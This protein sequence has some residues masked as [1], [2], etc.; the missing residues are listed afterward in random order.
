MRVDASEFLLVQVP[1]RHVLV[2]ELLAL[3]ARGPRDQRA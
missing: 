2:D 1:H 3:L